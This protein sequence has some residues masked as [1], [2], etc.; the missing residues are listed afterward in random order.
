MIP[1]EHKHC[2][3][4]CGTRAGKRSASL[5]PSVAPFAFATLSCPTSDKSA[6]ERLLSPVLV[7][8]R[9]ILRVCVCF[10]LFQAAIVENIRLYTDKYDEEFAPHLQRFTQGIWGLLMK[11]WT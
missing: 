8:L 6:S 9:L 3:A 5:Q 10:F 2:V 1:G 4:R 11:V 7:V